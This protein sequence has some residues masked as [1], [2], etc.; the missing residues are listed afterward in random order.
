MLPSVRRQVSLAGQ[1]MTEQLQLHGG[2][3]QA[4]R[5]RW[6]IRQSLILDYNQIRP[7]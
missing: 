2:F 6:E 1:D 4:L 3:D 5:M 7:V